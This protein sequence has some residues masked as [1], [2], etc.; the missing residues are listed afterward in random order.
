MCEI[1][2]VE[3]DYDVKQTDK[4]IIMIK[5]VGLCVLVDGDWIVTE[6]TTASDRHGSNSDNACGAQKIFKKIFEGSCCI[7]ILILYTLKRAGREL[8]NSFPPFH[9]DRN[10]QSVM[11]LRSA[12]P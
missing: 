1:H 12:D 7:G 5:Q 2:K 3:C 6:Q 4:I 11:A 10:N 9:I 8:M